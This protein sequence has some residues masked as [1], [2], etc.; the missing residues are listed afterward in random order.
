MSSSAVNL[1]RLL[2][3]QKAGVKNI[4]IKAFWYTKLFM[5]WNKKYRKYCLIQKPN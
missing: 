5:C 4:R 3:S 1:Q 2:Y